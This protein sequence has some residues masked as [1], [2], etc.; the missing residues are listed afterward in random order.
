MAGRFGISGE[1]GGIYNET[2]ANMGNRWAFAGHADLY[3]GNW[4]LQLQGIEYRFKPENPPGID[5]STVQLGA[6]AFPFL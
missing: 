4:N 3:V 6:F 1:V 2:T 5:R